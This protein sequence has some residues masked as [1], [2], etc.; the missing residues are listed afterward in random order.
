MIKILSASFAALLTLILLFAIL[1]SA[2]PTLSMLMG[3]ISWLAYGLFITGVALIIM[4][5]LERLKDA[6]SEGNDYKKY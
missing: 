5:V 6:K 4:L 3:L 1:S 2:I